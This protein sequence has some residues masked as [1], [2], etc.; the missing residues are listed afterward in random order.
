MGDTTAAGV[1][2]IDQRQSGSLSSPESSSVPGVHPLSLPVQQAQWS[3]SSAVQWT[4][5]G[6]LVS[7]GQ[8]ALGNPSLQAAPAVSLA[9]GS[10]LPINLLPAELSSLLGVVPSSAAALSSSG[11]PVNVLLPGGLLMPADNTT[12]H[13]P[14]AS[15]SK[16]SAGIHGTVPISDN[17]GMVATEGRKVTENTNGL[18]AVGVKV[19]SE[20]SQSYGYSRPMTVSAHLGNTSISESVPNKMLG[21][22]QSVNTAIKVEHPQQLGNAEGSQLPFVSGP[23]QSVS[24]SAHFPALHQFLQQGTIGT[25]MPSA[26]PPPPYTKAE[27]NA[28][29]ASSSSPSTTES[30][31]APAS[32]RRRWISADGVVLNHHAGWG[33]PDHFGHISGNLSRQESSGFDISKSSLSPADS[34]LADPLQ[35][36]DASKDV[37]EFSAPSGLGL[38]HKFR[39]KNRPQP[40]VIPSPVGHF[41]FQSRLRS[42]CVTDQSGPTLSAETSASTALPTSSLLSVQVTSLAGLTPYTPPPML[43]PVRTGSGLFCSLVQ[44]SPKSAPVG[45]RL[46]LQRSKY[47]HPEHVW[48]HMIYLLVFSVV[49]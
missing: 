23:S 3:A 2:A 11:L 36:D 34:H 39:R 33:Y 35:S 32:G 13:D 40:L 43:S 26:P 16:L 10:V 19:E 21:G 49:S 28:T 41:G 20:T 27:S 31:M 37:A 14:L 17:T 45:F 8:Q 18:H 4:N 42:P 44:P 9:P 7:P 6:I 30:T 25:S 48:R 1:K 22:Y 29:S 24:S 47:T 38:H 15:L 5:S 46:G 12:V